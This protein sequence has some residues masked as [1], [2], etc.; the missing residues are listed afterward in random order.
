MYALERL[1][2]PCGGVDNPQDAIRRRRHVERPHELAHAS[3]VDLWHSGQIENDPA[4]STEKESAN[5]MAERSA[6]RH[7]QRALDMNSVN[8]RGTLS[9]DCGQGPVLTTDDGCQSE[10]SGLT[11]QSAGSCRRR[12]SHAFHLIL[13]NL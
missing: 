9:Q 2:H 5:V 7:S 6:D 3:G 10:C 8:S 11:A 4:L 12:D 1:A 13:S